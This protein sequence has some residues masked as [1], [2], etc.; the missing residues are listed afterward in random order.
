VLT[1]SAPI[2]A[3]GQSAT[4]SWTSVDATSCASSGD[5]TGPQPVNG[6]QTV[7]TSVPGYTQYALTCEGP[8]GGVSQSVTLTAAGPVVGYAYEDVNDAGVA[9]HAAWE[10]YT[11]IPEPNQL[12]GLHTHLAVP[13]LPPTPVPA[14]EAVL[15]VWPGILPDTSSANDLPIGRGVLQP[16]LSWGSSC[17]PV[18]QPPPFTTWW[19]SGQYV[20][21]LGSDPGYEGCQ[22]G[23]ALVPNVGDTLDLNM[24]LTPDSGVWTQTIIDTTTSKTVSFPIDMEQQGQNEIYFAIETWYAATLLTPVVFTDTTIAFLSADTTGTCSNQMAGG[25]NAYAMTPPILQAGDTQ[26]YIQAI[27]LS[28]AGTPTNVYNDP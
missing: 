8:G 20:N 26:C 21:T 9:Y 19:I 28:T 3:A 24:S 12:I 2:L 11:H 15:F 6:Q 4:L 27:Y 18:T 25:N 16:V 7:T 22:S 23:S 5:W 17:A 14:R 10:T 1:V 13:P